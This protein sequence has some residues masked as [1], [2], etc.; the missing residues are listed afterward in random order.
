MDLSDDAQSAFEAR[1]VRWRRFQIPL[2]IVGGV[3]AV[4]TPL[5]IALSVS[6]GLTWM[7]WFWVV[8]VAALATWATI[9]IGTTE[10]ERVRWRRAVRE[11]ARLDLEQERASQP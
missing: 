4:L 1:I 10:A 5:T 8:P 3:L 7:S 6:V 2:L 11:I 9:L